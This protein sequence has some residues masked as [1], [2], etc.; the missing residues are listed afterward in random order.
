MTRAHRGKWTIAELLCSYVGTTVG[1]GSHL[2]CFAISLFERSSGT[3][4]LPKREGIRLLSKM[5]D[6]DPDPE[7]VR[8][9]PFVFSEFL[10]NP[11]Q[12]GFCGL[13]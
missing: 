7:L 9:F 4:I 5:S 13:T 2:A 3:P 10:L 11:V 6:R 1:E 8:G 12:C